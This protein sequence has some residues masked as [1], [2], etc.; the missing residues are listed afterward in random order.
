MEPRCKKLLEGWDRPATRGIYRGLATFVSPSLLPHGKL[1]SRLI[2]LETA[3]TLITGAGRH[4]S[5]NLKPT[6]GD[7][8]QS[9]IHR[10][11]LPSNYVG[12]CLFFFR[13]FP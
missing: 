4:G 13:H 12:W 9:G 6:G 10:K 8:D 2:L 11:A 5:E 3:M 7:W 1:I